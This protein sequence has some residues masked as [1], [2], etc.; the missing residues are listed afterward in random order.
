MKTIFFSFFSRTTLLVIALFAITQFCFTNNALADSWYITLSPYYTVPG[1]AVTVNGYGFGFK[2]KITVLVGGVEK[3]I[4]ANPDGSFTSSQFT[5]PFSAINSKIN[6]IASDSSG[7]SATTT[8]T[9]GTFFPVVSANNYYLV[10]GGA[11][12]FRGNGFAPH[13]AVAITNGG[14][15]IRTIST[16]NTGNFADIIIPV[17]ASAGD[18]T[19]TFSGQQSGTTHAVTVHVSGTPGIL[20][21]NQYYGSSGSPLLIQGN[22]FGSHE[23]VIL[24]MGDIIMGNIST[25]QNGNFLYTVSIPYF[26]APGVQKITASGTVTGKQAKTSYTIAWNNPILP[27]ASWNNQKF[28]AFTFH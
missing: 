19:Y 16:G 6:I 13:E 24:T 11:A 20:K 7:H 21:L 17:P 1:Q 25:D 12:T 9:V 22:F 5:V 23:K 28:F 26:S 10:P 4:S 15:I 14:N 8:L 18:Q 3:S 2:E 27:L